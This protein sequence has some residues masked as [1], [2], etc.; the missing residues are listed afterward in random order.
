[1]Q[2]ITRKKGLQ[3]SLNNIFVLLSISILYFSIPIFCE[4]KNSVNIEANEDKFISNND[5][6]SSKPV[7]G[8]TCDSRQFKIIGHIYSLP[9]D[10]LEALRASLKLTKIIVNHG[11]YIAYPTDDGSFEITNLPSGSY[12]IDIA[13]PRFIYEPFRV[14]ITSRGK[15]RGRKINYIQPSLVETVDYPLSFRPRNFHNY[16]L[17]RETWRIMDILLNPMVILMVVPLIII[18]LLPKMMNPQEMQAQRESMPEYNVPELSEMITNVF[19]TQSTSTSGTQS[20]I[21]SGNSKHS[22]LKKQR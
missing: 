2:R 19:G 18:W 13:H 11:Q 7:L 14:D 15:V 4:T 12:A 21:T 16:F 20:A 9:N 8:K 10:D 5:S 3:F 17:P 6:N 22:R 1:M